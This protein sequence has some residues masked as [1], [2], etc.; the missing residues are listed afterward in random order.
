MFSLSRPQ[1]GGNMRLATV[2]T[3]QRIY[4]RTLTY[5]QTIADKSYPISLFGGIC[6]RDCGNPRLG[7]RCSHGRRRLQETTKPHH[8]RLS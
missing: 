8:G 5:L 4:F 7:N 6:G 3:R 1:H 2:T